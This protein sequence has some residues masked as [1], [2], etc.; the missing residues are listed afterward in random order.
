MLQILM[1]WREGGIVNNIY[2]SF[3]FQETQVI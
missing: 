1:V 3:R 2:A